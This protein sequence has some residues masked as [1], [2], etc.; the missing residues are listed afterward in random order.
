MGW[1]WWKNHGSN[2]LSFETPQWADD[3]LVVCPDTTGPL[4]VF[5]TNGKL[6]WRFERPWEI[7]FPIP[8]PGMSS[9]QFR[10]SGINTPFLKSAEICGHRRAKETRGTIP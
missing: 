2:R 5:E 4:S 8:G 3:Q 10:R 1:L 7:E 9:P 6:R